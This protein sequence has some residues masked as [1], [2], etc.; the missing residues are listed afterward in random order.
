[1]FSPGGSGRFHVPVRRLKHARAPGICRAGAQSTG[2]NK[3]G[4][5]TA[6]RNFKQSFAKME[7]EGGGFAVAP[8]RA[9]TPRSHS[10]LSD[11]SLWKDSTA[12]ALGLTPSKPLPIPPAESELETLRLASPSVGAIAH[13]QT[14]RWPVFPSWGEPGRRISWSHVF[15]LGWR[16]VGAGCIYC[17]SL[18]CYSPFNCS[19]GGLTAQNVSLLLLILL[20]FFENFGP[21]CVRFL[22]LPGREV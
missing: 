17:I 22:P 11:A 5:S 20:F 10:P 12:T 1:M 19:T 9:E 14:T 6:F 2:G 3:D 18:W 15:S 16:P 7:E 8:Y 13:H 4:L 21:K